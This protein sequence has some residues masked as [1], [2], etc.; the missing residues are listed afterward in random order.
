MPTKRV[1]QAGHILAM[2]F[3]ALLLAGARGFLGAHPVLSGV[4]LALVAPVYYVA[5][6]VSG[7]RQFLH[8]A[9]LL[10][11]LGFQLVVYGAGVRAEFQP[12][13][14]LVPVG[15]LLLAASRRILKRIEGSSLSLYGATNFVIG[16][17]SFWILLR[18]SAQFA[19]SPWAT[20]LA[21]GGYAAYA[22]LGFQRTQKAAYV[23]TM[24][25]L[26]SAAFFFLLYSF[27]AV[28]LGLGAAAGLLVMGDLFRRRFPVC[29]PCSAPACCWR[30][31]QQLCSIP[32]VR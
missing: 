14:S 32:G 23:L 21:L 27:P 11:V 9:S 22:W 8:P 30:W 24:V 3:I 29:Y 25:V 28:A 1:I 19:D 15:L 6:R 2:V 7:H 5:A 17:F 10:V 12:L 20:A 4:L 13:A 18:I 31:R 26:G 16:A